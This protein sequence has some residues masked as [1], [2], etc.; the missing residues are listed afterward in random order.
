[1]GRG[2]VHHGMSTSFP[3]KPTGSVRAAMQRYSA[4]AS[5]AASD[6]QSKSADKEEQ[7]LDYDDPEPDLMVDFLFF[8]YCF[9]IH[10]L[11]VQ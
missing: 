3:S 10:E 4:A 5:S 7:L 2:K 9:P 6:K 8:H 11:H 1:M